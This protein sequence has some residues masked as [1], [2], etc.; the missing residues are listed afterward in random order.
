MTISEDAAP[1]RP[2]TIRE[3]LV[4]AVAAIERR[5]EGTDSAMST[6]F[7]DLDRRLSGG[8]RRGNLIIIAGRPGMGKTALA[9]GIAFNAA[10][11]GVPTLFLSMEMADTELAD[12]LVAIAGR[13]P[14]AESR[15]EKQRSFFAWR[16]C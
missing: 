13:V 5:G 8:F 11:A 4:R 14:P 12:R 7:D 6:G 3:V 10:C 16:T 2:Q 15:E 9:A 1:K